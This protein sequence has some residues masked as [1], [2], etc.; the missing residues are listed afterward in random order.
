MT[1]I[2]HKET[3]LN[4]EP[5]YEEV[6]STL[7]SMF[8]YIDRDIIFATLA[9]NEGHLE[10]TINSLLSLDLEHNTPSTIQHRI[11]NDAQ[12]QEDELLAIKM[13]MELFSQDPTKYQVAQDESTINELR[14]KMSK[15][16]EVAKSKYNELVSRFKK[17]VPENI[18]TSENT[19]KLTPHNSPRQATPENCNINTNMKYDH[20]QVEELE[21]SPQLVDR[22]LQRRDASK[23]S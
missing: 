4:G 3:K 18:E 7:Q 23:K 6:V 16:S 14:E 21:F 10:C 11:V 19:P 13:Q 17:H 15:I 8:L 9:E 2:P 1:N 5:S 12:V 20:A 22:R